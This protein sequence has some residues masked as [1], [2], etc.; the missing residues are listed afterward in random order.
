MSLQQISS[1]FS[2]FEHFHNKMLEKAVLLL[3]LEHMN[4]CNS[5]VSK[6]EKPSYTQESMRQK[7]FRKSWVYMKFI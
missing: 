3:S 4:D 6:K 2:T 7:I 1:N 5:V